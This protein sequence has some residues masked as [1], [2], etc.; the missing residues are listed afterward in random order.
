MLNILVFLLLLILSILF[1]FPVF[2]QGETFYAFDCL[3]QY[4]PWASFT[5]D[6]QAHNTLITDPVNVFYPIH[7]H[8]QR[9]IESGLFPLWNASNFCGLPF[10]SYSSPLLYF[11]YSIFPVST[12]HDLLLFCHLLGAGIF[13]YLYLREIKLSIL[14]CLIG[15]IS[16]MFNGYVMVWFEFENTPMTAMTLPAILF[17][18]ERYWKKR[19]KSAFIGLIC[20]LSLSIC[21]SYAHLLMYQMIF[22]GIYLLYKWGSALIKDKEIWKQSYKVML[23][24]IIAIII[25]FVISANFFTGHI[26]LYKDNQREEFSYKEL[27]EKTGQLPSKYLSTLLF[28]DLFGN[29]VLKRCFT[30]RSTGSQVYNNYNELCIYSGIISLFLALA[31]IPWIG[32]KKYIS[33]FVISALLSITMA[34]G[35]ILYYPLA[36]FVPGLSMS[37]PTRILYLFGFSISILAACGAHLIQKNTKEHN[38]TIIFSWSLLIITAIGTALFVQT[39]HGIRWL[40]EPLLKSNTWNLVLNHLQPYFEISSHIIL[41]QVLMI[42]AA[43]LILITILYSKK[44]YHK[45]LL[46]FM[47]ILA[48]SYDLIS[49]GQYYNTSSPKSLEFPS[50][51]AIHFLQNDDSKYRIISFG[52]F[53]HNS[54]AQFEIEDIGGYSS[55][56]PRRYGEFLHL[57]QKG[58]GAPH[59]KLSRWTS[60]NSFGSPLLDLINTKYILVPASAESKSKKLKLVYDGEIKIYQNL[61]AFPRIFTVPQ[62]HL[63]RNSKDA[64][65]ILAEFS[66]QDFLNKVIIESSTP[67]AFIENKQ[68]QVD[69]EINILNYNSNEIKLEISSDSN[70]F[71]VISDNYHPAWKA[72]IDGRPIDIFRANYIM[73]AIQVTNGKHEISLKFKPKLLITGLIVTAVGWSVLFIA[74]FSVIIS[75]FPRKAWKR[76]V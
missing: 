20:V 26:M 31:C 28:P 25:S 21:A 49:F 33:F 48:L 47:A 17:F 32:K 6:F 27:F 37:T 62:Y 40:A 54:L 23:C 58:Q 22:I 5:P 63:V 72:E 4:L 24:S 1:F 2:F 34:M 73:R 44:E 52:N 11:F 43:A 53:L 46:L 10:L 16:W 15:A 70:C 7:F 41:K 35:S 74:I 13:T 64:Y 8:Y 68:K 66:R 50:T 76:A 9:S 65:K 67:L 39:E 75:L 42:C 71:L 69:A 51:K 18:I 29:P 61:Q 55:F 57:S 38:F 14:A 30:P 60:F 36:R 19:T 3:L 59:E 45:N 12:A 56:Y